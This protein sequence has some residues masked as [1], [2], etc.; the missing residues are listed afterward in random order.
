MNC[1]TKPLLRSFQIF[2]LTDKLTYFIEILTFKLGEEACC[3]F[4]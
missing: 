2:K 1:N 4:Q 3:H